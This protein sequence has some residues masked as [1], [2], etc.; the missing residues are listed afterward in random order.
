MTILSSTAKIRFQDCDP[1][2][3]LNNARYID[4]FLNARGDQILESL[5][6]D[7]YGSQGFSWV[8]G[9]NQLAYFRP[10]LLSEVVQIESQVIEYSSRKLVIEM[11]MYDENKTELKAL[12][13]V[14]SIPIDLKTMKIAAHSEELMTTFNKLHLPVS[15]SIFEERRQSILKEA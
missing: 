15:T 3:H 10:A 8:V 5:G 9:T 14:T 13:W 7:I 2:R 12:L 4:Y 1:F 6:I 11:R